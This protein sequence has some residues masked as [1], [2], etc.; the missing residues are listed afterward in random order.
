M[1]LCGQGLHAQQLYPGDVTN[2]GIVNNVDVLFW[3]YA[4]GASGDPRIDPSSV[5][6]AEGL[7][8]NLWTESFPGGAGT[9]YAYADCN[10]D[11]VVD[12]D[13]LYV[14]ID[15]YYKTQPTGVQSDQF[16]QSS[17]QA[18]HSLILRAQE[19]DTEAGATEYIDLNL[20][21]L[22]ETV[23]TFYGTAFTLVYDPDFVAGEGDQGGVDFTY[24]TDNEQNVWY[25][26]VNKDE[27]EYFIWSND[28]AGYAEVVLYKSDP[29]AA[30]ADF[31]E[32]GRF[33]IVVEEVIFGLEV[34]PSINIVIPHTVDQD[35]K[36]AGVV[37]G[38]GTTFV[39]TETVTSYADN[40]L[41]DGALH[42]YPNPAVDGNITV[43][44]DRE[45]TGVIEWVEII[46]LNGQSVH[47]QKLDAAQGRVNLKNLPTGAYLIKVATDG[48]NGVYQLI[49]Q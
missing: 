1:V 29:A 42:F 9:N 20:G 4:R 26:G 2:N 11:G 32:I 6:Q 33:S 17:I 19:P 44:L 7:P 3:S 35:F 16:D 36:S 34:N 8:V 14:I 37:S 47:R 31:G 48:G 18:S 38:Q 39:V 22:Q 5:W 15:N 46:N 41:G 28:E 30:I 49:K 13:D 43:E 21:G 25:A 45:Q 23:P 12:Q 27:A 10:G 24:D 40:P